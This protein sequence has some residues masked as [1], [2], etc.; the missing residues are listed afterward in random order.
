[1]KNGLAATAALLRSPARGT[2]PLPQPSSAFGVVGA[3][4]A[5]P[6]GWLGIIAKRLVWFLHGPVQVCQ[7][8]RYEKSSKFCQIAVYPPQARVTTAK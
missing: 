8:E 1:M 2:N 4:G 3:H 7:A 6:R 5:G